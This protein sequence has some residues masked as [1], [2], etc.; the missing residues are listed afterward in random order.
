MLVRFYENFMNHSSQ[1]NMNFKK[2]PFYESTFATFEHVLN[3]EAKSTKTF[4]V[5]T[6]L[7]VD[8][9]L[10]ASFVYNFIEEL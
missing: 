4:A 1:T 6:C 2:S 9:F 10:K 7:Q 8:H 3:L 5:E